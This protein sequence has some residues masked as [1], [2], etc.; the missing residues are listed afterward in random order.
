MEV[1]PLSYNITNLLVLDIST[2]GPDNWQTDDSWTSQLAKK[3]F[4]GKL[5]S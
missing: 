5:G 4:D 1:G 2:C 3:L